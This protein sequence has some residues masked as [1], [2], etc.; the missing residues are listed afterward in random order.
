MANCENNVIN[1]L[2][3]QTLD[4]GQNVSVFKVTG[5]SRNF[6]VQNHLGKISQKVTRIQINKKD[7]S[8]NPQW[9]LNN[10]KV[11]IAKTLYQ[12]TNSVY[13][14]KGRPASPC[15]ALKKSFGVSIRNQ[16]SSFDENFECW[17]KVRVLLKISSFVEN[18]DF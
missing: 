16:I 9:E 1:K 5:N 8:C 7:C 14:N 12:T 18:S 11:D 6:L 2:K 10:Y 17:P 15:I 13:G 4:R 3:A